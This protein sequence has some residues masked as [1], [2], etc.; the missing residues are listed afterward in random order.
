MVKFCGDVEQVVTLMSLNVFSLL[1]GFSALLANSITAAKPIRLKT[2]H[3]VTPLLY[4]FFF[5]TELLYVYS[6]CATGHFLSFIQTILTVLTQY[7]L[8]PACWFIHCKG[9]CHNIHFPVFS[10]INLHTV[11]VLERPSPLQLSSDL[12]PPPT[13]K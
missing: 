13:G 7:F 9:E 4:I 2:N 3:Q 12:Q 1:F 10:D 6:L 5:F 8:S 11:F